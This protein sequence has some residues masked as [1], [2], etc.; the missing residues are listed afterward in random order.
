MSPTSSDESRTRRTFL[1]HSAVLSLGALTASAG[2][3]N[4]SGN[5]FDPTA[6]P[7]TPSRNDW[8]E[9]RRQFDPAGI[10]GYLNNG[11]LG[12][13]PRPVSAAI[14]TMADTLAADPTDYEH[15]E[16]REALRRQLASFVGTTPDALALTRSTTE[17]MNLLA[18]GLDWREGDEV[19]LSTHE[20]PSAAD[21][22]RGIASRHGIT[23]RY[24]ELPTPGT[25]AEQLVQVY[26]D[27]IG[28]RTRLL[29][30]SHIVFVT[31]LVMPIAALTR[32]AH[33]HGLLISV[34]GAHAPGM[35]PLALDALG[36]D[37]Y[38][39]SGQKWLL[40]G[41]GTGLCLLRPEL[42]AQ[43]WPLMGYTDPDDHHLQQR[44]A[45]RYEQ[46]GQKGLPALAGLA[47]AT[48]FADQIGRDNI[49]ARVVELG[50]RLRRGLNDIDGVIL[51]TPLAPTLS[52]GLTSFSVG[53]I[54]NNRV[55]HEL[56][57]QA[58]LYLIPMPAGDLNA[59]RASTHFYNTP[60]EV[61]RLLT[62]VQ[63]L[64]ADELDYV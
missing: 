15:I 54:P 18:H 60:D 36:C 19:V 59:V 52:A 29:V 55:A 14:S 21:A 5:I 20:H 37:H 24:V 34:D 46:T 8:R 42:Q 57:E 43:V 41:P 61:D 49:A 28:P 10:D 33:D 9:L 51:H 23:L 63:T 16:F 45:R 53:L 32:L 13:M 22:Y 58:G 11:S 39:A 26:R 4:A 56:H 7:G 12:P 30:V 44:G 38:A 40:G 50:D 3:S 17:G 31:G 25:D 64:A 27:A 2:I 48:Q 35:L 47:A 62:T 1:L 6:T